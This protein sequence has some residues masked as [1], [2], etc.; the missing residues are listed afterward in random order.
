MTKYFYEETGM[1]IDWKQLD[2]LP[3]IDTLIDI[4]VGPTGTPDLYQQF[5]TQ[6]LILID[7]LSESEIFVKENLNHRNFS[8]YKTALGAEKSELIIN[9]EEEL[10]RSTLLN[11]SDINYEGAPIE[12]RSIKVDK[13]DT[14]LSL[15]KN[16]GK[17]GIKIDTEGYE[18]NVILGASICLQS[19]KFVLA[20]VRHNHESFDGVYKMHEFIS[21]MTDNGFVLTMILTAKPFI[22]DLCFQ[23]KLDL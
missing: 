4:G 23:P 9:V 19:T 14:V 2:K 22:A 13:L 7:P 17:I 15:E 3:N 10:G 20:E 1:Y 6:K 18:L 5:N 12:K 21:A 11:V 16:L 8:F